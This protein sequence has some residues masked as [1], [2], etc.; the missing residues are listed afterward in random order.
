MLPYPVDTDPIVECS[1]E[2]NHVLLY[3]RAVHKARIT[4]GSTVQEQCDFLNYD[5]NI[6]ANLA[7]IA[8]IV[9]LHIYVKS[10]QENGVIKPMLLA[11]NGENLY[12]HCGKNR[13][14]ASEI[15]PELV[16]FE[17]FITTHRKHQHLFDLPEIKT[18]QQFTEILNTSVGTEF[19]FTHSHKG[20]KIGIYEYKYHSDL[21]PAH[22]TMEWCERVMRNYLEQNSVIFTPHWFTTEIDWKKYE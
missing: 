22:P 4:F 5:K 16:Y 21:T 20:S 10:I 1:H 14:R 9:K 8:S 11:Y 13:M 19:E 7:R 12:A 6:W 3:D 17:S 2:G 15:L 18:F